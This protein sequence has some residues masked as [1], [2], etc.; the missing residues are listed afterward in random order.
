M[1]LMLPCMQYYP[2]V[3][4]EQILM[5]KLLTIDDYWWASLSKQLTFCILKLVLGCN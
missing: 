2:H 4:K 5:E 1:G 3:Q